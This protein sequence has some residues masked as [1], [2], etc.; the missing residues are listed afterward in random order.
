MDKALQSLYILSKQH[1]QDIKKLLV[2]SIV[3]LLFILFVV[4]YLWY[5]QYK[6]K[7]KR[8]KEHAQ[9]VAL[10]VTMTTVMDT[11]GN[12]LNNLVLFRMKME[13]SNDFSEDDLAEFDEIIYGA[14]KKLT[15]ISKMSSFKSKDSSRVNVLDVSD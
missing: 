3:S 10:K 13:E 14:N 2:F 12:T 5:L 9:Y 4:I 1:T 8:E 11:I 7:A 6:N 15:A